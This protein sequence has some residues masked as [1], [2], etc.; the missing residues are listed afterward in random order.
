MQWRHAWDHWSRS[1]NS[2]IEELLQDCKSNTFTCRTSCI[3][4]Q[5][6]Q[7]GVQRPQVHVFH[8]DDLAA[9]AADVSHNRRRPVSIS[10]RT[11]IRRLA[12]I[13]R[14]CDQVLWHRMNQRT[15]TSRVHKMHMLSSCNS[16]Y[17]GD[18]DTGRSS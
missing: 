6:G 4:S 16:K 9:G 14:R 3:I 12:T 11:C 17:D 5:L 15:F 10:G 7:V 2:L 1:F 18:D 13:Q 8:D